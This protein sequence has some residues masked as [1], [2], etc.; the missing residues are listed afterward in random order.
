MINKYKLLFDILKPKIGPDPAR[1][2]I[3]DVFCNDS[4]YK[5][6]STYLPAIIFKIY[7]RWGIKKYGVKCDEY[8]IW[9]SWNNQV[10]KISKRLCLQL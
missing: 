8:F 3:Y 1:I 5:Y 6:K 4:K 9:Q 7:E 10:S 2:I